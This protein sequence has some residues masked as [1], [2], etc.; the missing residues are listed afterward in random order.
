MI[1]T[2]TYFALLII[3][4][5]SLK[6]V[7]ATLVVDYSESTLLLGADDVNVGGE[8][9]DVRFSPGSCEGLFNGCIAQT[10]FAFDTVETANAASQAL[11]DQVFVNVLDADP[12]LLFDVN[13]EFTSGCEFSGSFS[14]A[15]LTSFGFTGS[16]DVRV[17]A[18]VNGETSDFVTQDGFAPIDTTFIGNETYA[19][20]S[21]ATPIPVP[22]ALGVYFSSLLFFKLLIRFS[23][24]IQMG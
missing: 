5:F 9:F 23:K 13:P 18:A 8:L 11:L 7:A 19:I 22:G 24:R 20:W 3:S 6:G 21:L 15:V 14:C 10:E 16:G 17:V 1:K 12:I 4:C 2:S